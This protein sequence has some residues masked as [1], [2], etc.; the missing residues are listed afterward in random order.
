MAR[1]RSCGQERERIRGQLSRALRGTRPDDALRMWRAACKATRKP[2]FRPEEVQFSTARA[3]MLGHPRTKATKLPQW[4]TH[5]CRG[6][7]S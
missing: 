5:P 2:T 6:F 7:L 4:G 1:S 3:E